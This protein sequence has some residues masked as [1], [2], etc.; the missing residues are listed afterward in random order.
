[1]GVSPFDREMIIWGTSW[2]AKK[3]RKY[4]RVKKWIENQHII[5][6]YNLS[7]PDI[8]E[9][10]NQLVNGKYKIIKS[11]PSILN[12][13]VDVFEKY[14]LSYQP[15]VIQIGGEKLY[16]FQKEKI[17]NFFNAS[18]FDFYGARDMINIAQNCSHNEGLHIFMENVIVE[19]V[20]E[21]GNPIEEGEGDLVITNLH[22]YA[23]PFIRY[24]IGDRA[25]ISKYKA[26]SCGRTLPLLDE[27]LGRKSDEK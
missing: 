15:D 6:G 8:I 27:V 17:E 11:Y 23:M 9:I 26:C 20:D 5:S 2:G 7:D 25:K 3:K 4:G 22:N 12:T 19:V 14:N 24:K 1:M 10:H 18:V 16:G 13:I 21:E